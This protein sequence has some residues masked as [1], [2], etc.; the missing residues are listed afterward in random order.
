VDEKVLMAVEIFNAQALK[1]KEKEREREREKSLPTESANN[2]MIQ[3]DFGGWVMM[4]FDLLQSR[5]GRRIICQSLNFTHALICGLAIAFLTSKSPSTR[6]GNEETWHNC[7]G[8]QRLSV[9][10]HRISGPLHTR[11][12]G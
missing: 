7:N 11:S 5:Q 4:S 10:Y 2:L 12:H 8:G 3:D 6:G 9:S 1:E